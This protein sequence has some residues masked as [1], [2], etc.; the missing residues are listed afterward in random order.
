KKRCSTPSSRQ[1]LRVKALVLASPSAMTL[2]S[3]NMRAQSR[4]THNR[5]SS[6]KS[7]LS[8]RARRLYS[9][10]GRNRSECPLLGKRKTSATLATHLTTIFDKS[11]RI[12]ASV[13]STHRRTGTEHQCRIRLLRCHSVVD[14]AARH[15]HPAGP[16]SR[17]AHACEPLGP[18]Y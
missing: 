6:P 12:K 4:S 8:C 1:N 11:Q 15:V 2:S 14:Q 9:P 17:D 5:A 18:R 3:S 16:L 13:G 7:G 10:N